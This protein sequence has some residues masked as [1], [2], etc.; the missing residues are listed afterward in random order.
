M[1]IVL[2]HRRNSMSS[3]KYKNYQQKN[4]EKAENYQK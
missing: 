1:L 4:T 3:I 2:Y